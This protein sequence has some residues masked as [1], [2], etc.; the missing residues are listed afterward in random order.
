LK[1]SGSESVYASTLK[2]ALLRKD[3]TF[4]E[5]DY[6]FRAFGEM[7]RQMERNGVVAL[8]DGQ[9]PG[10]PGVDFAEPGKSED[11]FD[12][13]KVT[14][15]ELQ[16]EEDEVPLSGLKDQLRKRNGKWSEKDFGYAGFLQFA[17]A[18]AAA[19]VVIMEWD[20]EE[21]DYFLWVEN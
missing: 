9:A 18:A 6:G 19:G 20:D 17:K 16:G 7:L 10:D 11:T 15:Q 21:G 4:S 2:R 8:T 3:P 13:L 14:V 5:G 1:Q 12:L